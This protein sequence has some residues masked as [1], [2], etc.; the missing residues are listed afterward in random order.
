MKFKLNFN[1]KTGINADLET[2]VEKLIE[3]KMDID[4]KHPDKTNYQ[5]KQEEK[6]KNEELRQKRPEKKHFYQIVQ[7]EKR[8]TEELKQQ[9]PTKKSRY[10]IAQEEKRKTEEL[11]HQRPKRKTR[12]QIKQEEKRKNQELQYRL[13]L[14]TTLIGVGV[15]MSLMGMLVMAFIIIGILANL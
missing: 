8:K 10:Q 14:Q 2:D 5:I 9:R 3:K 15:F 1:S 11:K 6:R 13:K 7:E 4:N 12:Y